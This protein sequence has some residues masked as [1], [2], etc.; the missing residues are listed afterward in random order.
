VSCENL[1]GPL[2]GIWDYRK[3][4]NDIKRLYYFLLG[5]DNWGSCFYERAI[6]HSK[7]RGKGGQREEECLMQQGGKAWQNMSV[8]PGNH[9]LTGA[10]VSDGEGG[11]EGEEDSSSSSSNRNTEEYSIED[12]ENEDEHLLEEESEGPVTEEEGEET[13]V[14]SEENW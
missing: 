12:K 14:D 10:T 13:S 1:V 4:K 7:K 2:V 6:E 8:E 11:S 3:E 9:S 5:Q